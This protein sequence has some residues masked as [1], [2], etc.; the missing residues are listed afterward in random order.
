MPRKKEG[1][2]EAQS[3]NILDLREGEIPRP[4]QGLVDVADFANWI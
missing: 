1:C 3:P 2:M 4:G